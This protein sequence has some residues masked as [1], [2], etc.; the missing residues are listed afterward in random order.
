MEE[1]IESTANFWAALTEMVPDVRWIKRI[2]SD[3]FHQLVYIYMETMLTRRKGSGYHVLSKDKLQA[4]DAELKMWEEELKEVEVESSEYDSATG[5]TVIKKRKTGHLKAKVVNRGLA[6]IRD[7]TGLMECAQEEIIDRV[8][9]LLEDCPDLALGVIDRTLTIRGD[10]SSLKSSKEKARILK[11]CKAA[12]DAKHQ[13]SD[14][15]GDGPGM[16]RVENTCTV[17]VDILKSSDKVES[18]P[19]GE[20]QK[21]EMVQVVDCQQ[22]EGVLRLQIKLGADDMGWASQKSK[23]GKLMLRRVHIEESIFTELQT[24]HPQLRHVISKK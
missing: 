4:I 20:L 17:R 3:T 11:A 13:A 7:L 18:L 15:G 19:K 9:E 12:I 14:T 2:K 22:S 5:E 8:V 21:G 10:F 1:L 16:Y 23:S 24:N 6:M